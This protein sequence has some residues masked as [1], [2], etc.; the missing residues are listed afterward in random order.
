MKPGQ[1]QRDLG[2][3]SKSDEFGIK[4][5]E[6]CIQNEELCIQMMNIAGDG[7]A[8]RRSALYPRLP[9]QALNTDRFRLFWTIL[10]LLSRVF[11]T[12]GPT[13]LATSSRLR[14]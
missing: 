12:N 2:K 8:L 4:N 5:E 3:V 7:R 1:K 10:G 6:F 9:R 14:E 13:F 11:T